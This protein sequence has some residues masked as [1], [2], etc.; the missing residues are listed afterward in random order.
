VLRTGCPWRYLSKEFPPWE[1]VYWYFSRWL[2]AGTWVK[3]NDS[4]RKEL[5]VMIGR[6]QQPT[7]AIIDSQSVKTT[8]QGGTV[9]RTVARR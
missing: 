6:D 5:R 3:I 2:N 4:L 7:A 1:T 8:E 9:A